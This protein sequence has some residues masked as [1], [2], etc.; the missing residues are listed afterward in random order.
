MGN[1]VVHFEIRSDDPDASRAF[2]AD[3]FGWTYPAGGL[4][5]YTYIDSGVPSDTIPGGMSPNQGGSQMVTV[6]VGVADV[7]AALDQAQRLGGSVVQPAT[8]AP[9]VT[10]GLFRDPLGNVVGVAAQT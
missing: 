5:G 8:Q 6:F 9:G 1:P 4:P 2:Y 3:M 10:F 7:T